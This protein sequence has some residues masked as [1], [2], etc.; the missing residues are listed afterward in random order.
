MSNL[1][2]E[3]TLGG[4]PLTG[5]SYAIS[6]NNGGVGGND[7]AIRLASIQ[8]NAFLDGGG[9]TLSEAY[10][11]LVTEVGTRTREAEIN[12][13]ARE[14]LLQQSEARRESVS[15]VNL[16]EEAANLIKYQQAYAANA[17]VISVANQ[18]FDTLLNSVR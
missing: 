8:G 16:D 7:N 18:I 12:R 2:Y 14:T 5:D 4:T 1:G 3:I 13:S 6:Y 11:S 15:G 10:G 17:Q 9:S